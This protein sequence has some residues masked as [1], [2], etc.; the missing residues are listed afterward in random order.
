L[1]LQVRRFVC[2][3]P[4]CP[5]VT[6]AEQVAGLTRPYAQRTVALNTALQTI[7]LAVGG[8]AGTRLGAKLGRPGSPATILRRV[9]AS[10]PAPVPAPRVVGIDDR[11]ICKGQR[12]GSIIVDVERHRPIALL[13]EHATAPI[14]KWFAEHPSVEIVARD[15]ASLYPEALASGAAQ[16]QQV[17]DGWHLTHNIATALQELLRRHTSSLRVVA[18]QLTAQRTPASDEIATPEQAVVLPPPDTLGNAYMLAE[19]LREARTRG[20]LEADDTLLER[21]L[22]AGKPVS[23][24]PR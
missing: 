9:R 11:A 18:Q 16:A 15:R 2:D 13:P 14:A 19:L 12:Y 1:T 21:V 6:F 8:Q 20:L 22:G 17:A 5:R 23:P 4:T 3:T 7:G 10:V 24:V